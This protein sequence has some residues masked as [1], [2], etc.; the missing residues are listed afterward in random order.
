[1]KA[2]FLPLGSHGDVH[3]HI[4]LGEALA[5]RGHE[6][7]VG[8]NEVFR[9][10]AESVG[11]EFRQIGDRTEYGRIF[12]DARIWHPIFGFVRAFRKILRPAVRRHVEFVREHATRDTLILSPS[13][14]VG[15]RSAGELLGLPVVTLHLSPIA[16]WSEVLSPVIWPLRLGDEVPRSLKHLQYVVANALSV[17]LRVRWPVN[18]YRR[19]LG[20]PPYRSVEEVWYGD[21]LGLTLFPGWFAPRQ[22]DWPAALEMG[23]FPNWDRG[24][25][26]E[27]LEPEVEAFLAD[28]R[29][30]AVFTFGTAMMHPRRIFETSTEAC[31]R[32]GIRGMFLSRYLDRLPD[33]LPPDVRAFAHAP[34]SRVFPR[35]AAVVHHGGVG[36]LSQALRAG[37]P[38][39]VRPM[40]FDQPDNGARLE[41]L[42]V[43]RVLRIRQYRPERVAS[44]LRELIESEDVAHACRAAAARFEHDPS[45][46]D[47][48]AVIER[49]ADEAGV[50]PVRPA[51]A[52]AP[53]PPE[54]LPGSAPGRPSRRVPG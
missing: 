29:P 10:L 37:V 8:A 16:F 20:L 18:R 41:R 31:R 33:Q 43:G 32:L 1:M 54:P 13:P 39:L 4:A 50:A 35:A 6:V 12:D 2:L 11:L 42:G 21:T 51:A 36:T 44:A 40:T 3:P 34:F 22:P 28:E 38:Q 5:R 46:D 24:R 23:G 15:A 14:G 30:F 52:T 25:L 45:L 19:E 7:V 27:E 53:G 49:V 26:E 9:D 17:Q 48:C 47:L